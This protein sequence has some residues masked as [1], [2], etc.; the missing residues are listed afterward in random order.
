MANRAAD[1][2]CRENIRLDTVPAAVPSEQEKAP[3]LAH[4]GLSLR[5]KRGR[6]EVPKEAACGF[7]VPLY[8]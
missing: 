1:G 4:R 3:V 8:G 5:K 7:R 6:K 2:I